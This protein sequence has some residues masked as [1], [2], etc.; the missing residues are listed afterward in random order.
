MVLVL[1]SYLLLDQINPALVDLQADVIAPV[2][3]TP[4]ATANANCSWTEVVKVTDDQNNFDYP[5]PQNQTENNDA[6]DKNSQPAVKNSEDREQCCC[7]PFANWTYQA[8]IEAQI[9]D[10]SS[11]L[12]SLIACLKTAIPSTIPITINSI[13][14]SQ[15]TPGGKTFADCRATGCSH[16][17]NSCHYGGKNGPDKSYAVDLGGDANAISTAARGCPDVKFINPEGSHIHVSVL[18]C[19]SDQKN[20]EAIDQ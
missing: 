3:T 4:V 13:S 20:V 10:A 17:A 11:Q 1:C 15:I 16:T 5:C 6:C 7:L 14:D 9:K 8:G 2:P 18:E 12:N 19:Q